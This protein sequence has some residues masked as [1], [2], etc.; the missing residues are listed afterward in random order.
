[1]GSG[2]T[3][4]ALG[5]SGPLCLPTSSHLGQSVGEVAGLPVQENHSDYPRVTQHALVLGSSDHVEPNPIVLAQPVGSAIQ[6]DPSQ[7]L[8]IPESSCLGT[9]AS[10]IK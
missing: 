8:V 7:E 5:G 6:S 1:M 4:S 3:H 2:G 10:A 9:R